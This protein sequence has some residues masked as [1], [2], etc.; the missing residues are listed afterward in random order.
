MPLEEF[1]ARVKSG[2]KVSFQDSIAAVAEHYHYTPTRFTNGGVANE[3]GANEGSCKL[4]YFA[5]LHGL[6]PEQTLSL[7]GDYYWKDVLEHPEAGNH[8][9][10]RAFMREGW[11]GVAY[12]GEAL[13]P[14]Y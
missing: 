10:I 2:A 12:E 5:K 13:R 8:A 11:A 4:F 9:N 3:A 1:L 14:K 7:F 6:T